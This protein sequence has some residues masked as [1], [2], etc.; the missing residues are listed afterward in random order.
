MGGSM[1]GGARPTSDTGMPLDDNLLR[2]ER[3]RLERRQVVAAAW[4]DG[5][6]DGRVD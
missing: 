2:W 3:R 6:V 5:R 4:V 1:V